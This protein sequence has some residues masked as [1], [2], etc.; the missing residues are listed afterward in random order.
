MSDQKLTELIAADPPSDSDL[1]Y[2][3]QGT[4]DRKIALQDLFIDVPTFASFDNG[5]GFGDTS[6]TLTAVGTANSVKIT[7]VDGTIGAWI[8]TIPNGTVEGQIKIVFMT[9]GG[10]PVTLAASNIWHT[11]VTFTTVG[12]SSF[13]MWS[14]GKWV[15]IGGTATVV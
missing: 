9:V 7:K 14:G 11:S 2:I 4:S 5:F 1:L 8:L 6:E 3:F 10:G 12:H 13:L 15:M